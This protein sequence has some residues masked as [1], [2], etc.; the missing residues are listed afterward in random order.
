MK[1]RTILIIVFVLMLAFFVITAVYFSS[2][3]SFGR[4][5]GSAASVPTVS[6]TDAP[7]PTPTPIPSPTATPTPTP[8]PLVNGTSA[9]LWDVTAG[10][11]LL[12]VNSHA[13]LPM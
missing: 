4:G 7:T 5:K 8:V 12:N 6:P 1:Q 3:F 13:R 9:Y 10:R 11:E 2:V